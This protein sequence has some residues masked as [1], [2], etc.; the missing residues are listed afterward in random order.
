MAREAIDYAARDWKS[1]QAGGTEITAAALN[2]METGIANATAAINKVDAT[3]LTYLVASGG[4]KATTDINGAPITGPCYVEDLSNGNRWLDKGD[5]SARVRTGVS[6][7]EYEALRDSVSSTIKKLDAGPKFG[8][9]GF[10]FYT[11]V[12]GLV[13][14]HFGM[15]VKSAVKAGD[16]VASGLPAARSAIPNIGYAATDGTAVALSMSGG[17]LVVSHDAFTKVDSKIVGEYFYLT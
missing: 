14:V 4:D 1:L 16:V 17:N 10:S 8:E 7:A 3:V 12:G 11:S 15:S 5:G 2:N 6:V 9:V 13:A